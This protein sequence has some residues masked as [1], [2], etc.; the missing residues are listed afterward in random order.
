VC[1]F[2]FI[3]NYYLIICKNMAIQN[4]YRNFGTTYPKA[5][6]TAFEV[7]DFVIF[8]GSGAIEP[9][10]GGTG[11]ILGIVNEKIAST[12]SDYATVRPI[13]VTKATDDVTFDAVVGGTGSATAGDVGSTIDVLAADASKVDAATIGSGT[14]FVIEAVLSST[15]VKVKAL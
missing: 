1:S 4:E 6:S 3:K 10:T 8:D 14:D 11:G 9:A 13:N 5:A 2:L 15:V 12:D 7:G